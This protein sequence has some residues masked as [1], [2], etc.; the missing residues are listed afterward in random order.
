MLEVLAQLKN[1]AIGVGHDRMGAQICQSMESGKRHIVVIDRDTGPVLRK[2]GIYGA[3]T[4]WRQLALKPNVIRLFSFATWSTKFV[5][6]FVLDETGVIAW[7]RLDGVRILADRRRKATLFS[8]AGIRREILP[9]LFLPRVKPCLKTR[10]NLIAPRQR[11]AL[12]I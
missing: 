8:I 2:A 9:I 1:H 5:N 11:W 12:N 3:K 6:V 10:G 7:I 4:R